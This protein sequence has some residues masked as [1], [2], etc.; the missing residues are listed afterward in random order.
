M[1]K[2][3]YDLYLDVMSKGNWKYYP[4]SKIDT[5]I[6]QD[7]GLG[8]GFITNYLGKGEKNDMEIFHYINEI[9]ENRVFRFYSLDFF[10]I[11]IVKR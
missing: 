10:Y 4:M 5:S 8:R 2:T 11:K 9:D 6:L 7:S 1:N 3:L